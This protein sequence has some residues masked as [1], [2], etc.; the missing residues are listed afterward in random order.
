VRLVLTKRRVSGTTDFL[1][2]GETEVFEE[3]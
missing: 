3:L 2:I 1:F